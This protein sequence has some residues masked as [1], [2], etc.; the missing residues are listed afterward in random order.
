MGNPVKKY[1]QQKLYNICDEKYRA[2]LERQSDRYAQ[3]L[4]KRGEQLRLDVSLMRTT[5]K[6]QSVQ[7]GN[8]KLA[9]GCFAETKEAVVI[10]LRGGLVDTQAFSMIDQAM[11]ER[12]GLLLAYGQEDFL[13][14]DGKRHSP[15]FK[16]VWSPDTL[17]TSFYMGSLIAVRKETYAAW[18]KS[19]NGGSSAD[20]VYTA[21]GR[22]MAAFCMGQKDSIGVIDAFLYHGLREEESADAWI[23]GERTLPEENAVENVGLNAEKNDPAAQAEVSVIIPS[24]D[25]PEVLSVCLRS[26]REQTVKPVREIIVIDN[27]SNEKNRRM[28][29]EMA[30]ELSFCYR[31]E[32]MEFNF[33][34][35]CNLGASM[36]QGNFL[37]FLNDDM[38]I[39]QPDWLERLLSEAVKPHAGAVGAKL[40]YPETT[41]IQ[42]AGVTNLR[43][44]PAH[45]LLKCDDSQVYYHGRNRGRHDMLAVTAACLLVAKEKFEAVGGFYEGMAVSYNDVEFCFSLYEKGWYNIQCN[46][47]VLYH[48]E[49]LSRGD[50][51]LSEQKWKRLLQEKHTLYTR[52][53][54]L[55]KNDPFYSPFLAEHFSDYIC[56]YEYEYERRDCYTG[57]K[58][59]RNR[60]ALRQAVSVEGHTLPVPREWCNDCLTVNVEHA[61]RERRLDLTEERDVYWIEGWSYVLGMDNCRYEKTLILQ[62]E[63]SGAVYE[64]EVLTRFRK[65]VVQILPEQTNVAL[66]GFFCRIP[67]EKIPAGSYHIAMLA[68]DRCSG[69]RLYK[70]TD[71]VL[72]VENSTASLG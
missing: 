54:K 61:R 15:W 27:G 21:L 70:E 40:L 24:K 57:L 3:F 60:K 8:I 71:A 65:D 20:A 41:L 31:Y 49:S 44:G 38:E 35:M 43:V 1:I 64:A 53:P 28:I 50:D 5:D 19:R 67:R 66:A 56:N 72:K 68:R 7:R 9:D 51:N 26:L 36:A 58:P 25:N 42:H 11:T 10:Y 13:T 30:E 37:L 32:P 63:K 69:Q 48:H 55:W 22:E 23:P 17:E 29:E 62:E 33:S 46:D 12:P 39:I 16:P 14:G 59:Y 18:E 2:E 6:E 52:H 34:R 4:L 47:V 45:K